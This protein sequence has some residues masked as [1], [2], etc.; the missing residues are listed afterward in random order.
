MPSPELENLVGMLTATELP[1]DTTVVQWR[2]AYD[3]LGRLVP[4]D[5]GAV[6]SEAVLGGRPALDARPPDVA[7]PGRTI[8]Y[9]HGGGY[10]IGSPVS[11]RSLATH[12]AVAASARVILLDYRL[13]PEHPFPAAVEDAVAA[14]RTLLDGGVAP[15]ALAIAGDSAGGGLT[16][17]TLLA[18]RDAGLPMPACAVCLSPWA[19]LTQSGATIETKADEDPMV[20]KI[21][22]DSWADA[23]LGDHEP[24]DPLASPVFGDLAGL[25]PLLVHVGSREVLLD[26]AQRLV[27]RAR[28]AGVDVT[29]HVGEE[30]IHVWHQFAGMIPEGTDSVRDVGEWVA[31]RTGGGQ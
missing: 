13:A 3:G 19:D 15:S 2:E 22:L 18:L 30:L 8:L 31:A 27:A 21:D 28:E 1:D 16:V 7:E 12:L 20:R 6:V 23:Y 10:A 11:H 17:A 14:Y 26:D 9:L 4:P 25:P 5:P 29:L 24:K